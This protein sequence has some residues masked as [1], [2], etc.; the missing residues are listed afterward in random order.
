MGMLCVTMIAFV[1]Y[2][3]TRD[4]S[5]TYPVMYRGSLNIPYDA[6]NLDPMDDE[7]ARESFVF[8]QPTN[9]YLIF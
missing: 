8:K 2:N 9:T 5:E 4:P 7:Y 6:V 1:A 3:L